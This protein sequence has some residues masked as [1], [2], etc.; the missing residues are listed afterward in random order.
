MIQ[1]KFYIIVYE[2]PWKK[3][4]FKNGSGK[5]ITYNKLSSEQREIVEREKSIGTL[6]VKTQKRIRS[7]ST[8]VAG[9]LYVFPSN[10]LEKMQNIVE[11]TKKEY[12]KE[13]K[14]TP[15]MEIIPIDPSATEQITG[16][17][18]DQ[19]KKDIMGN[20]EK[21]GK[22]EDKAKIEG[23]DL[24]TSEIGMIIRISGNLVE[25]VQGF[26][27]YSDIDIGSCIESMKKKVQSLIGLRSEEKKNWKFFTKDDVYFDKKEM[28]KKEAE[29]YALSLNLKF[30]MI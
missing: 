25:M 5:K 15:M 19:V 24:R 1:R 26:G 30:E 14:V 16:M 6:R 10:F 17:V 12:E 3:T 23:R 7:F 9:S 18:K 13:L 21:I 28:T 4:D 20:L 22:I 2:V 29:E 11:R 27:I 8:L